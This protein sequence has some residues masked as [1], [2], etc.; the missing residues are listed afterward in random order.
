MDRKSPITKIITLI[1]NTLNN[2]SI[3]EGVQPIMDMMAGKEQVAVVMA[4]ATLQR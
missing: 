1:E 4:S 2:H 3:K